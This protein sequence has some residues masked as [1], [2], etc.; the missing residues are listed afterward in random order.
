MLFRTPTCPAVAVSGFKIVVMGDGFARR[1]RFILSCALALGL[2]VTLCPQV[3]AATLPAT[4]ASA[5]VCSSRAWYVEPQHA[6]KT[7]GRAF[8]AGS[9]VQSG[10]LLWTGLQSATCVKAKAMSSQHSSV[11]G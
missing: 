6:A 5:F 9:K 11:V 1:N 4:S 8:K 7:H 2:G 3:R 10:S